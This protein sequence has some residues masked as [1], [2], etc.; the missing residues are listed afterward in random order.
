MLSKRLLFFLA[1]AI[2]GLVTA[3][4]G[5]SHAA[6]APAHSS[7]PAAPAAATSPASSPSPTMAPEHHKH[8][9]DHD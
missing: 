9:K 3:C 6:Q 5:A 8:H 7:A 2:L 1:A 4:G